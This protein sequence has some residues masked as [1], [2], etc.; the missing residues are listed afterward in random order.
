MFSMPPR[1]ERDCFIKFVTV[2]HLAKRLGDSE[3]WREFDE[4]ADAEARRIG[5]TLDRDQW[6]GI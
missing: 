5:V 6:L 1:N 4:R 2:A 3:L